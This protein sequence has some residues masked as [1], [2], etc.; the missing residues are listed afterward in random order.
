[1]GGS[2][3]SAPAGISCG[4]TCTAPFANNSSVTLTAVPKSSY[5]R[6][7]GWGGDCSGTVN[8]CSVLV[9][10]NKNVIANFVPRSFIYKEF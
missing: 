7:S 10:G 4:A 6:F 1:L 2:V 5:W 8:T 9:N 3:T